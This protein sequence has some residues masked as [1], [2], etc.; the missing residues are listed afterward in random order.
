V[1]ETECQWALAA[2]P[3]RFRVARVRAAHI[4]EALDLLVDAA[5]RL[6]DAMLIDGTG[7]L[8]A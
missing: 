7:D 2:G 5:D 6:H 1:W 4:E 8:I 3:L